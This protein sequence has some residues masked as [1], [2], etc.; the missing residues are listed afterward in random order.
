MKDAVLE[1]MRKHFRPEFLNRVDEIIVFHALSEAHLKKIVDIQLGLLQKRLEERHINLELTD[2]AKS[3]LVRRLRSGLWARPLKR[4][5]AKGSGDG[6]GPDDPQG[7]GPRRPDREGGLRSVARRTRVQDRIMKSSEP[8]PQG[9]ELQHLR[10]PT[11]SWFYH[12][13]GACIHQKLSTCQA[14][15]FTRE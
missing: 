7:R 8:C 9:A 15:I 12:F 2:A 11:P 13:T 5:L 6:P 14:I 3:H 1:E 4:T 10:A